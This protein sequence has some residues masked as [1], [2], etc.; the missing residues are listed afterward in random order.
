MDVGIKPALMELREDAKLP[1][2]HI[3][4][5]P[6]P[7]AARPDTIDANLAVGRAKV[8]ASDTFEQGVARLTSRESFSIL[9]DSAM[10]SAF[11]QKR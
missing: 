6:P 2:F 9:N 4:Q 1:A 8:E 11:L 5:L 7:R 3:A 10:L